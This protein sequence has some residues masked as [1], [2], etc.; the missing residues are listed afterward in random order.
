VGG[1]AYQHAKEKI[2]RTTHA[3]GGK[4]NIVVY[5][6]GPF[7]YSASGENRELGQA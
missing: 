1:G 5:L 6:L 7:A 3:I 2:N 4:K